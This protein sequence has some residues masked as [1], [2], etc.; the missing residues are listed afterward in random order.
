MAVGA[1]FG[2]PA[3]NILLGIGISCTVACLKGNGTYPVKDLNNHQLSVSG[4][5][6]LFALIF[7]LVVIPLRKFNAGRFYGIFLCALY[8]MYLTA[9]LTLE[10]AVK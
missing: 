7:S 4:G 10:F 9:A 1:C 3:L 2:G 8:L 5:F 6:L